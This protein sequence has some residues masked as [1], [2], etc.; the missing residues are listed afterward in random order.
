VTEIG[1]LRFSYA[2][3]SQSTSCTATVKIREQ[4][5]TTPWTDIWQ[6]SF[7]GLQV[8]WHNKPWPF[9]EITLN[10]DYPNGIEI[11]FHCTGDRGMKGD[12]LRVTEKFTPL[13]DPTQTYEQWRAA[14]FNPADATDDNVS[15][16]YADPDGDGTENCLEYL[17][18]RDPLIAGAWHDELSVNSSSGY[19]DF[20]I[21]GNA[22]AT[23]LWDMEYSTNMTDWYPWSRKRLILEDE[24]GLQQWQLNIP[25]ISEERLFFRVRGE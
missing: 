5:G 7:T 21:P 18:K 23:D 19:V 14:V 12:Q 17:L 2:N 10:Q 8:D 16:K 15:G 20:L 25:P 22:H 6:K 13:P 3:Y 9:A 11:Q 1:Y 4:Q 24:N